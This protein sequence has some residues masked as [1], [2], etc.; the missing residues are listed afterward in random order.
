MRHVTSI[1]SIAR[2]HTSY[3]LSP[4][5]RKGLGKSLFS[6]SPAGFFFRGGRKLEFHLQAS[7]RSLLDDINFRSPIT[8]PMLRVSYSGPFLRLGRNSSSFCAE[9]PR[10]SGLEVL[11]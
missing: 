3:L 4:S 10:C 5:K 8:S 2:F 11:P 9:S 7:R 1:L 6:L